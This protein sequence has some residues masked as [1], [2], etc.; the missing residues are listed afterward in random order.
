MPM[1]KHIAPIYLLVKYKFNKPPKPI[2]IPA[3]ILK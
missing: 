2:A 1:E 3:K